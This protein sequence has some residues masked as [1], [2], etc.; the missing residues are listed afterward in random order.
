MA[1]IWSFFTWLF[2]SIINAFTINDINLFYVMGGALI[3]GCLLSITFHNK[4]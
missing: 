3:V 2:S 4:G 1:E